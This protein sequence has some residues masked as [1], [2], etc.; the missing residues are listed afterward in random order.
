MPPLRGLSIARQRL[1][2]N[3]SP[4]WGLVQASACARSPN[5]T[6]H[7]NGGP[8]MQLGNAGATEGPP[9]VCLPLDSFGSEIRI[10]DI[11]RV[12]F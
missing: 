11:Q 10:V 7:L 12:H 9:S 2:I 3:M 6:L 5:P 1:A 4:R 8:A